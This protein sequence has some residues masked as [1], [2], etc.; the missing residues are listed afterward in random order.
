M[1]YENSVDLNLKE[2]PHSIAVEKHKGRELVP[3]I[4]QFSLREL[5]VDLEKKLRS[6]EWKRGGS[7]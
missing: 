5:R 3:E 6:S 2:R 1:C 7:I 4:K